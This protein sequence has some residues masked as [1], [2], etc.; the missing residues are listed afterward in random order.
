LIFALAAGTI[1]TTLKTLAAF[2]V[3]A[4]LLPALPLFLDASAGQWLLRV[5]EW[6]YHALY[7]WP[8]PFAILTGGW[9]LFGV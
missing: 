6:V 1:P 5:S 3:L 8:G 2:A 4:V 9:S 7:E